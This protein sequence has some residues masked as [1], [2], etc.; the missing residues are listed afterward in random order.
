MTIEEMK[1]NAD[2]KRLDLEKSRLEYE[3][4]QK[5][6]EGQHQYNILLPRIRRRFL[7]SLLVYNRLFR[8]LVDVR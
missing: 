4:R 5:K 8:I 2:M 3:E 1:I 6:E 7:T